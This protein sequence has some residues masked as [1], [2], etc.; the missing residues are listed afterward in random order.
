MTYF[1]CNFCFLVASSQTPNIPQHY[2]SQQTFLELIADWHW[3]AIFTSGAR[4]LS[5]WVR[6]KTRIARVCT[7]SVFQK[8]II[9]A[10]LTMK[11]S[12]PLRFPQKKKVRIYRSSSFK[13]ESFRS[14]YKCIN[15][16]S[17]KA[18][19][20]GHFSIRF[21]FQ[22]CNGGG[23]CACGGAI[24]SVGG[25]WSF[26]SHFGCGRFCKTKNRKLKT[27]PWKRRAFDVFF[28]NQFD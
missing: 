13:V 9:F 14:K 23:V 17:D 24:P 20:L 3:S 8:L 11:I 18:A 15:L 2:D 5:F 28:S 21:F 4:I 6:K 12:L 10:A 7:A 22:A 27:D 16:K 26:S 1:P 25:P 19:W